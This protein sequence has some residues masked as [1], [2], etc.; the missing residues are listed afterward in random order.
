MGKW[1]NGFLDNESTF[2][3]IMGRLA[4]MIGAN[5]MFLV[6]SFPVITVGPALASL[7]YVMLET[8][9]R[10]DTLNPFSLFWK[11]FK[12]NLKQGILCTL[13]LGAAF[14]I[15]ILD[16]RFCRY[17]GGI[18]YSFRFGCY[19][20]LF[21]LI[22]LTAY[23]FP[24]MAAFED[25]IPNLLRNA[26]FFAFRKPWKIIP[27]AALYVVPALVTVL[28]VRYRPLYAFLWVFFGFGLISMMVS[29]LL[30]HD[31]RQFQPVDETDGKA[32][33]REDPEK[34][35]AKTEREILREMRKLE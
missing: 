32:V 21:L 14:M 23:L 30:Y 35:R 27:T 31:I 4:V 18:W 34:V 15:L 9:H 17:A 16:I 13:G 1:L 29:E 20:L 5:L 25:T 10:N 2:G 7:F 19:A 26:F 6:F 3:R 11:G 33:S 24:V 22:V 28:D 8:I 12:D